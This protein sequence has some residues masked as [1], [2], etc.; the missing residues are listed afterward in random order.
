MQATKKSDCYAVSQTMGAK[1]VSK[2]FDSKKRPYIQA[3]L[4]NP[5]SDAFCRDGEPAKY[6]RVYCIP[7]M[8]VEEQNEFIERFD[9]GQELPVRPNQPAHSIPSTCLG[10]FADHFPDS[11]ASK[12]TK[13]AKPQDI[14]VPESTVTQSTFTVSNLK[15]DLVDAVDQRVKSE[16]LTR[17]FVI[18][19]LLDGFVAGKYDDD[20]F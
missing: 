18:K 16:D 10:D 6:I 20:I 3:E 4:L 1:V 9:I 19:R 5:N 2:C 8:E 7:S 13:V 14:K 11:K 17:T 15:K 12:E